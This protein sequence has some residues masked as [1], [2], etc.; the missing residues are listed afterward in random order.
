[1]D[2][3]KLI[4]PRTEKFRDENVKTAMVKSCAMCIESSSVVPARRD[5]SCLLLPPFNDYDGQ[6]A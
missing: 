3:H 5:R 6:N 1:M 4:Y 2:F